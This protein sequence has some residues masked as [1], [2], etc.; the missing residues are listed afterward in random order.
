[1]TNDADI[2]L[3]EPMHAG[4]QNAQHV[5]VLD[6]QGTR[7]RQR[8]RVGSESVDDFPERRGRSRFGDQ[9]PFG[10]FATEQDALTFLRTLPRP[11]SYDT[12]KQA[13]GNSFT[14]DELEEKLK[15]PK[16]ECLMGIYDLSRRDGQAGEA[17]AVAAFGEIGRDYL[18]TIH[19][20]QD[21]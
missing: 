17:A 8:Q 1:M 16:F 5:P 10:H 3:V 19:E 2:D 13:L 9:P 4:D 7:S 6:R 21:E 20:T 18:R 11:L 12:A 15:G 14:L